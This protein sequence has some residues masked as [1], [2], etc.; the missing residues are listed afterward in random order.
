MIA[1]R[2]W[3]VFAV[4][5]VG[6][7]LA[8]VLE[9]SIGPMAV[10]IRKI[11]PDTFAYLMGQGEHNTDALV[12]G[13]IRWPRL[14]VALLVGAGLAVC[15]TVLQAVFKNPMSDPGVIGVSSGGAL[16]AVLTIRLGIGAASVWTT[17]IGA[18]V[19]G[20]AVVMA[21]YRLSTVGRRTNLYALLLAGVAMSSLCSSVITALLDLAPLQVMQQMLFWLFGGLDGSNWSEV[22]LL[23][24]VDAICITVFALIA[25]S[26]DIMLTGEEHAQGV[27]VP[28]QRMKQVTLGL[29]ALLV[30]VCVSTT[31]V[32]SFVGLIVPHVLRHFL[33]SKH[34]VLIPAAALGGGIL[35]A[36][37]DLV[38]R[39]IF[40]PVELSVGIVTS[41]LGAPFFLY[42]LFQRQRKWQRG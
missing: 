26:Y 11:I 41:F 8:V 20:L 21:I 6:L 37:S 5:I 39:T 25:W 35:L 32:I 30:G 22:L 19:V 7:V 42:L 29:C 15:G 27:G 17:P 34:R 24:I 40:A 16:G 3:I 13:A 36:L 4:L 18:F 31:G 2:G 10:P 9:M 23:A 1:R 14:I 28:V 38:A 12:V 33:G